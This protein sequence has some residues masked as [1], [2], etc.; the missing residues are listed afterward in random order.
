MFV[1]GSN[2]VIDMLEEEDLTNDTLQ[3]ALN[4]WFRYV[5]VCYDFF[6]SLAPTGETGEFSSSL[7]IFCS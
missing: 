3:A 4:D 5:I 7:V 2:I 1:D 6:C